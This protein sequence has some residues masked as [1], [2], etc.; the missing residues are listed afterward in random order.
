MACPYC[1]ASKGEYCGNAPATVYR[2]KP[3]SK[4]PAP[5]KKE[6]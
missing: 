3:C 2:G 5:P 4:A 6:G 1:G